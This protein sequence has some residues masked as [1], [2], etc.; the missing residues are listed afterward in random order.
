MAE[1]VMS[2]APLSDILAQNVFFLRNGS[3][4]SFETCTIVIIRPENLRVH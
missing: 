3:S 1:R 4:Y 2:L